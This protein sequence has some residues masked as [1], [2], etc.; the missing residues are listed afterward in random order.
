MPPLNH[1]DIPRTARTEPVVTIYGP[2]DCPNCDKAAGFFTRA[3][4]RF[5]K[6]DISPGDE[7]HRHVTRT[8]GHSAA[9]VVVVQVDDRPVLHWGGHRM[10]LLV[11]VKKL[12]L[13][14]RATAAD[15]ARA[16][17]PYD[18]VEPVA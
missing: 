14:V 6:I 1:R 5:T 16:R 11:A 17:A 4:V 18:S 2:H 13:S 3:Q 8:L 12:A 10:D 15:H 7:H 9:P